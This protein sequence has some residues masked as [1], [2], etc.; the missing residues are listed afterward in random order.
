MGLSPDKPP[1]D[2]ELI[3][4][5]ASEPYLIRRPIIVAGEKLVIGFDK[6]AIDETLG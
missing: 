2:D 1:P 4:L 5:M 3:R 6:K